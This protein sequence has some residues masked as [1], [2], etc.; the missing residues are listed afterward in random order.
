MGRELMGREPTGIKGAYA[1]EPIVHLA[2]RF[3][4]ESPLRL[5][6]CLAPLF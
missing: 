1:Q 4:P 5:K 6:E 2:G 3:R